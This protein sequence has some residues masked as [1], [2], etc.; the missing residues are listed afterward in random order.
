MNHG[1]KDFVE[2]V[3]GHSGR[4]T[5]ILQAKA[6]GSHN[7]ATYAASFNLLL[8]KSNPSKSLFVIKVSAN[9]QR[10]SQHCYNL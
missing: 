4:E 7:A 2:C 9:C 1:L 3:V 10:R 8:M 5:W 6:K